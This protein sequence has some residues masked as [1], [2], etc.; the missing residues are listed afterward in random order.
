MLTTYHDLKSIPNQSGNLF[1]VSI[2]WGF[3]QGNKRK[4]TELKNVRYFSYA[5]PILRAEK[6]RL[7]A[8]LSLYERLLKILDLIVE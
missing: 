1:I 7:M 6:G 4:K 3:I 2:F 5:K 8:V